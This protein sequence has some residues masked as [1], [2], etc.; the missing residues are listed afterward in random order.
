MSSNA[1]WKNGIFHFCI[2]SAISLFGKMF[3]SIN[4][5]FTLHAAHY[6]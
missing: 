5:I 1:G 2:I 6:P 3:Y 4:I